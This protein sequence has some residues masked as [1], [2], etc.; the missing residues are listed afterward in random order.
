MTNHNASVGLYYEKLFASEV[1]KDPNTIYD[2]VSSFSSDT[3]QRG[4][5]IKMLRLRGNSEKS[6]MCS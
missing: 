4:L 1:Q 2:I 5:R 3:P 6:L